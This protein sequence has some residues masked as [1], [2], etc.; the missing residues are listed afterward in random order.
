MTHIVPS[1]VHR[2]HRGLVGFFH[3]GVVDRVRARRLERSRIQPH[4]IEIALGVGE[5]SGAGFE[6]LRIQPL[7]LVEEALGAE[8]EHAAVPQ[9]FTAFDVGLGALAVGLLDEGGNVETPFARAAPLRI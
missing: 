5:G 2:H 8:Q 9:I 1:G 7:Q 6:H 3:H 4:E